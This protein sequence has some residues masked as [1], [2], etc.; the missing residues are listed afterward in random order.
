MPKP[1]ESHNPTTLPHGIRNHLSIWPLPLRL[2]ALS[3]IALTA[4]TAL[5]LAANAK[6]P[7]ILALWT[8]PLTGAWLSPARWPKTATA[9]WLCTQVPGALLLF[10]GMFGAAGLVEGSYLIAIGW[11]ASLAIASRPR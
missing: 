7:M 5:L 6:W 10:A 2:T 11:L 4:G 9:I 1:M 3:C 8:L